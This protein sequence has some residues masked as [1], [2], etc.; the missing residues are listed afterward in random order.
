MF[1]LLMPNNLLEMSFSDLQPVA[2][3]PVSTQESAETTVLQETSEITTTAAETE[4]TVA[5]E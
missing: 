3:A 4:T 5:V 1:S 2:G